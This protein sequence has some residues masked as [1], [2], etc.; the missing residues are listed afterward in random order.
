MKSASTTIRPCSA[1]RSVVSPDLL[2]SG[3]DAIRAETLR[4]VGCTG[5]DAEIAGAALRPTYKPRLTPSITTAATVGPLA[6]R[7]RRLSALR[8]AIPLTIE[9]QHGAG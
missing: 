2:T 4:L 6:M 8:V 1:A 5:F 7:R 3:M 9:G